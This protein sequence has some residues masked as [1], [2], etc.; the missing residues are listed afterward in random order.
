MINFT[1]L[2]L[3]QKEDVLLWRNHPNVRKWMLHSDP[4]T[5]QEHLLFINTLQ[6]APTKQYFLIEDYGVIYF[7]EIDFEQ[8]NAYFGL[9]A[10]PYSTVTGKG[11]ILMESILAYAINHLQ[12]DTLKLEVF[13]NN[14]NAIRLYQQFSFVEIERIH[15]N[16]NNLLVMKHTF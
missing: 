3:Q 10:N 14:F 13:A 12:L 5:L 11:K 6:N 9:Y 8:K 2:T 7:S 16:N 4:I 15:T 1:H